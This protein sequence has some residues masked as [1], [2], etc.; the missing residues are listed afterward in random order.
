MIQHGES[1]AKPPESNDFTL[2]IPYVEF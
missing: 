2:V 1:E